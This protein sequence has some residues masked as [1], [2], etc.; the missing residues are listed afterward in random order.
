MSSHVER[1]YSTLGPDV[2]PTSASAMTTIMVCV[3]LA[4]KTKDYYAITFSEIKRSCDVQETLEELRCHEAQVLAALEWRLWPPTVRD[5]LGILVALVAAPQ[6]VEEAAWAIWTTLR[7]F[8]PLHA[9]LHVT[10]GAV[11][12]LAFCR[13]QARGNMELLSRFCKCSSDRIRTESALLGSSLP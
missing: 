2:A 12:W 13:S 9:D 7:F 3:G 5:F 8:P 1:Y 10:A 11:L 6:P 4:S